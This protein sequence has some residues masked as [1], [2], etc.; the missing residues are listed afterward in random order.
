MSRT[1]T[2]LA[3][4]LV[5]IAAFL[6]LRNNAVDN[7]TIGNIPASS[8]TATP[9]ARPIQNNAKFLSWREFVFKPGH[10]KVLLPALPQHVSDSVADPKTK[11]P[12]KY[13]TFAVASDNGS[14]F[15][16]N[17]ITYASPFE[18]Q[19]TEDRLK[20]AVS[21]MLTRNSD[22]K[23]NST[24]VITF[25]GH[26]ALDFSMSNGEMRIEGRVLTHNEVMY[27]LSMLGKKDSFNQDELNYFINSFDFVEN[28]ENEPATDKAQPERKIDVRAPA[29]NAA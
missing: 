19:A 16:V 24:K 28:G 22:N 13:E 17:A 3:A 6:L 4:L 11:E 23:L 10:F 18:A 25:R 15:I 26:P 27:I 2:L 1:F 7:K 14:A 20:E 21:E 9:D 5:V 8:T 29:K 12:R